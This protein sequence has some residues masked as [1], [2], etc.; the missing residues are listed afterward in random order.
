MLL[1]SNR[2]IQI[3]SNVDG[4][5]GRGGGGVGFEVDDGHLGSILS[6]ETISGL[7]T[8]CQRSILSYRSEIFISFQRKPEDFQH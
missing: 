2:Q 1:E 5:G 8:S 6:P 7:P 4:G 3:L